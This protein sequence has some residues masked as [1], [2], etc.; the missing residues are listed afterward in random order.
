[1]CACT[2][3]YT[4]TQIHFLKRMERRKGGREGER[5]VLGPPK[6]SYPD[7]TDD[8]DRGANSKAS[9][10]SLQTVGC[11][12]AGT[13]VQVALWPNQ[14]GGTVREPRLVTEVPF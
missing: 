8:V 6:P 9:V 5:Q 3:I 11:W 2:Q 10:S 1:M 4:Q 14:P 13:T 12:E 7:P